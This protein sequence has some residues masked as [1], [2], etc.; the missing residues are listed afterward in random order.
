MRAA[1]LAL[2]L[3]LIA[4][5]ATLALSQGQPPCAPRAAVAA[6]LEKEFGEVPIARG[7]NDSGTL[8]EVFASEGGATYTV[9]ITAPNGVSCL[10]ATGEGW[11]FVFAR[12]KGDGA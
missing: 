7:L 4:L 9:V 1:V 2:V 5:P 8:I 3:P 12:P 10:A 11:E 6:H